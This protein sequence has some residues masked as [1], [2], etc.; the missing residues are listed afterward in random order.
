MGVGKP[1]DIIGAVE[2]GVDMFDCVIPTR[3]GRNGQAFVW[4]GVINIKNAKYSDD[5]GPLDSSCKCCTCLNFSRAYLNHLVKSKEILG[6]MLMTWHNIFY[7][8]ELMNIIR[9]AIQKDLF[10][11]GLGNNIAKLRDVVLS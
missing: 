11:T 7:Y 1:S 9:L 8:Q 6:S 2:R 4:D 10:D 3:S 5:Q